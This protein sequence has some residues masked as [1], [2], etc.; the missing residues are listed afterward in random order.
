MRWA[1]SQYSRALWP[2]SDVL[3]ILVHIVRMR[4]GNDDVAAL[5]V[6]I[7]VLEEN[8]GNM[9]VYLLFMYLVS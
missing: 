4:N 1:T 9:Y 5:F 3:S 2:S 8:I 7:M 6:K